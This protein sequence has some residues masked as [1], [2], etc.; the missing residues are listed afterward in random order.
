MDLYLNDDKLNL[1]IEDKEKEEILKAVR[2]RLDY[3]IID[4]IYLDE[5]EVSLAYFKENSIKLDKL[6]KMIFITKKNEVLIEETLLQAREYLPNLKN[7]LVQTARLYENK[8]INDASET[9]NQCLDGLEWYT[10]AMNAIYNLIDEKEISDRGKELL[11][12]LKKANT[13]AMVAMQNE[14]Y[15]YLSDIIEVE[16]VEYLKNLDELND[17]LLVK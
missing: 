7:A 2:E 16:V 17:K 6:D 15:D 8:R 1:D 14:N 11:D 12:K 9:L 10:D 3:E 4:K 5:V 13:R